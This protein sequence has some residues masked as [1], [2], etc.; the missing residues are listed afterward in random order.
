MHLWPPATFFANLWEGKT[1]KTSYLWI[2]SL[3]LSCARLCSIFHAYLLMGAYFSQWNFDLW[4]KLIILINTW[5]EGPDCGR[6]TKSDQIMTSLLQPAL[7]PE[8][9]VGPSS[10]QNAHWLWNNITWC[11]CLYSSCDQKPLCH[12]IFGETISLSPLRSDLWE[13]TAFHPLER[14]LE[15]GFKWMLF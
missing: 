12:Y 6:E 4:H 1:C 8:V 10:S 9:V 5:N 13:E 14:E 15:M 11:P 2:L 3:W 7:S